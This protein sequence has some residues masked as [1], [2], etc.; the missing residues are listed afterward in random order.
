MGES[1]FG[2]AI[3][4]GAL[5]L[6][7]ALLSACVAPTSQLPQV[8]SVDTQ[9]EAHKQRVIA[10]RENTKLAERLSQVAVPILAANT[11]RCSGNL[12]RRAGV[13]FSFAR[14]NASPTTRRAQ[15]AA[16]GLSRVSEVQV[17]HTV[18]GFP[19]DGVLL[20]GDVVTRINGASAYGAVT[21]SSRKNL[22]SKTLRVSLKRAGQ[23]MDVSV[24]TIPVCAYRVILQA[25]DEVN[26]FAG[27]DTIIFTTGFMRLMNSDRDLA[28]A[29]GH[30][31][32][33]LTRNHLAA[34]K[35]NAAVGAIIAAVVSG[36]TGVNVVDIG[37]N[38][39]ANA[40][41]QEF[42]AEADYV[43]MYHASR[44]G[45]DMTGAANMFRRMAAANPGSI[46]ATG[47]TH[48]STAS[49][50]VLVEKTAIE[51][52]SKRSRNLALIPNFKGQ[53]PT[54]IPLSAPTLA[55][56]APSNPSTAAVANANVASV[57]AGPITGAEQQY[58]LGVQYEEGTGQRQ[59]YAE[60]VNWYRKAAA[61]NHRSA[62]Y[63][64][65]MM[66]VNGHGVQ[67]N[68]AQAVIYFRRAAEMKHAKAHYNLGFML[69]NGRGVAKDPGRSLTNYIIASNLGVGEAANLAQDRLMRNLTREQIDDARRRADAWIRAHR[70]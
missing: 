56:Q 62:I 18:P 38:I 6:G 15:V 27:N 3:Q 40:F 35:A 47:S 60:A 10:I 2:G 50:A 46:H 65:G 58:R 66:Y 5:V 31:M 43:G 20:P 41:S 61:Q 67:Q 64:L 26:A 69:E 24:P 34:K 32:A 28:L 70:R 52:E 7:L 8:S 54:N 57:R 30:E 33:H 9:A 25:S 37:A 59:D 21:G 42:E 1:E 49:R 22:Q 63:N 68:N 16:L 55:A 53:P 45:W 19:A 29:F 36:V 11:D 14:L 39:G 44:A 48:P 4:K 12:K 51:I 23:V 17:G 13:N